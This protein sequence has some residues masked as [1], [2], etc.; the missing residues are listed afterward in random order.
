MGLHHVRVAPGEVVPELLAVGVGAV[1]AAHVAYSGRRLLF[2]RHES[3]RAVTFATCHSIDES[4][5]EL[6]WV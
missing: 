1:C 4:G 3:S 6:D 5:A 2:G